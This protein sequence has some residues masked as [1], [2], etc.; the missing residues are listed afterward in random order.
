MAPTAPPQQLSNSQIK[1][2]IKT[3]KKKRQPATQYTERVV[4]GQIIQRLLNFVNVPVIPA[5]LNVVRIKNK[6][7]PQTQTEL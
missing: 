2:K 5:I 7:N 3:E 4:E 1:Q 6:K